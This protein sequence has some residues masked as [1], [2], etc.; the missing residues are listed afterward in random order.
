[1]AF[2]AS[3]AL[4]CRYAVDLQEMGMPLDVCFSKGGSNACPLCGTR[5]G[6]EPGRVWKIEKEFVKDKIV[7][8]DFDE[9]VIE[10]RTFLLGN[11]FIVKCHR[12][13]AGFS[14][15][16]CYKHRDRDT[17]C[18]SVSGLIKH[19][20]QKHEPEEYESDRDIREASMK[21]ERISK[22]Y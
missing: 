12:E 17:I 4:F 7:T 16:L 21:E 11:R 5:L 10:Q 6:I 2:D 9:E 20:W 8:P 18:E 13:K 14:C 1:M 3:G 19:I 22:K 15:V